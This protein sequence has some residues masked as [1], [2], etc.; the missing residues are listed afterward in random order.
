M[1]MKILL[2]FKTVVNNISLFMFSVPRMAIDK[3]YR[4]KSKI[5]ALENILRLYA[6][7]FDIWK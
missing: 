4:E 1:F 7:N 6:C 5:Q 2:S 3:Q